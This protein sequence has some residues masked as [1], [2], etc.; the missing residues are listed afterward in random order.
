M[1]SGLTQSSVG[2]LGVWVFVRG[3]R[4]SHESQMRVPQVRG[5]HG[6][7]FVRGVEIPRIWGPGKPRTLMRANSERLAAPQV[8]WQSWPKILY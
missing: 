8:L 5:P 6:Q 2:P 7:V 4:R 3:R 1:P